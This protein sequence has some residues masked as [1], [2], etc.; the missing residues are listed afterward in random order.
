[1]NRLLLI[2]T[3]LLAGAT[4]AILPPFHVVVN[5]EN[6]LSSLSHDQLSDLFL[7]KNS[8]WS[9]GSLVLPVDQRETSH[10]RERF[11]REVHHKSTAGVR[12]YWQQRIFSGRDVPP[13][14]KDGDAE[15]IAFVR[16]HPNAI[17]YVSA[18]ASSSGIKVL[19]VRQ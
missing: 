8:T 16:K 12:A 5:E 4:P 3:L 15:V 2:S 13:P 10:V 18:A 11:T 9:D 7:K 19:A 6:P 14:E 1:M 17:G